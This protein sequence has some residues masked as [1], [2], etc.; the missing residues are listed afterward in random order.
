MNENFEAG[1]LAGLRVDPALR[2]PL[3]EILEER[4]RL[5]AEV[6]SLKAALADHLGQTF[7]PIATD[8]TRYED[9]EP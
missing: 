7:R 2:A 6:E 5:A 8:H 3:V 4:V 9:R 1:L